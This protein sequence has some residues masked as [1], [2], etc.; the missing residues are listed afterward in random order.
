MAGLRPGDR[1]VAA[2]AAVRT[3]YP[4]CTS[5]TKLLDQQGS[6]VALIDRNGAITSYVFGALGKV[7]SFADQARQTTQNVYDRYGRLVWSFDPLRGT[8]EVALTLLG[9]TVIKIT[10]SG[11]FQSPF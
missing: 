1:T 3:T 4:N 8:A 5:E 9:D 10:P 7:L 11:T 2:D 6:T